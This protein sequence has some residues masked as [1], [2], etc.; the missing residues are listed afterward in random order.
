MDHGINRSARLAPMI[1][2]SETTPRGRLVWKTIG[3]WRYTLGSFGTIQGFS[4]LAPWSVRIG[5][6]PAGLYST[7]EEARRA[8]ETAARSAGYKVSG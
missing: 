4:G 2:D 1:D 8:V 3:A 7:L 6:R 5:G